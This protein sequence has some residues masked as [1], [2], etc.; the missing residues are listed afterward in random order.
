MNSDKQKSLEQLGKLLKKRPYSEIS[1]ENEIP[2]HENDMDT[3]EIKADKCL[4]H[5]TE[6]R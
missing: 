3:I 1:K 2:K 6:I 4:P 5:R